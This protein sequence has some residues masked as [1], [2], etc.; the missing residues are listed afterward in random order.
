MPKWDNLKKHIWWC[1]KQNM[2][3]LAKGWKRMRFITTQ[4]INM[5]VIL[6]CPMFEWFQYVLQQVG[7]VG[8][9]GKINVRLFNLPD[10]IMFH[11]MDD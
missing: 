4:T 6:P 2:K 1:G 7:N 3:F 9:L 11:K 5:L 8:M 10:F